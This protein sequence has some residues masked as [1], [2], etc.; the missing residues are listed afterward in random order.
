MAELEE[1]I[2]TKIA[3]LVQHKLDEQTSDK[4]SIGYLNQAQMADYLSITPKTFHDKIMPLSP[5]TVVIDGLVRYP[6][7]E[8]NQWVRDNYLIERTRT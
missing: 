1:L 8:F 4:Q 6:V 2:A 3:K 5:P 7:D